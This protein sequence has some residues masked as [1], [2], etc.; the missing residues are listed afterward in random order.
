V[1]FEMRILHLEFFSRSET[2]TSIDRDLSMSLV[3][4]VRLYSNTVAAKNPSMATPP[5]NID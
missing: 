5:D 4:N 1:P 2:A 3:A